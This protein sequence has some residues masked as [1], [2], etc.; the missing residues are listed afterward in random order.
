MRERR[1]TKQEG[2]RCTDIAKNFTQTAVG[3]GSTFPII[4][5]G[6]TIKKR[7]K[8]GGVGARNQCGLIGQTAKSHRD[9]EVKGGRFCNLGYMVTNL[10]GPSSKDVLKVTAKLRK[11]KVPFD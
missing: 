10:P 11:I 9:C 3:K 1:G 4:E 7:K 6:S 8:G 5:R 2:W